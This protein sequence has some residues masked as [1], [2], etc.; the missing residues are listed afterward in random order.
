MP[1][2]QKPMA[3][4]IR[5]VHVR[6]FHQSA[7]LARDCCGY[8]QRGGMP[9]Y[10]LILLP[11]VQ[12]N[13]FKTASPKMEIINLL[14]T[15]YGYGR[16]LE[17]CTPTTGNFYG[18]LNRKILFTAHRL[19]YNCHA[20]FED[21]F[22]V[23]FRSESMDISQ[24]LAEINGKGLRYDIIL[25]D[26]FHEYDTSYRDLEAAF[27]LIDEGGMLVVHDCLP[28]NAEIATA[29]FIPGGWCGVTYKAYI[30]FVRPRR[31]LDYRTVDADYGCGLI[32]K[33]DWRS[34]WA[35]FLRMIN[36]NFLDPSSRRRAE[37]RRHRLLWRQWRQIN[38][39]FERAFCFF[40]KHKKELLNLISPDE[41]F[42][43]LPH[44]FAL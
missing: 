1:T 30:D 28:P 40:E 16:Y 12:M 4:A 19:M 17:L 8:R 13:H 11:Q 42:A 39:D 21:G 25:V 36:T 26:P 43:K 24:C 6:T 31:D 9:A 41:F 23:D 5:A 22:L 33:L 27:D 38:N 15:Q 44:L 2:A 34:R 18:N 37:R 10:D 20:A 35:K 3:H 32:R 14:A 7:D 29:S